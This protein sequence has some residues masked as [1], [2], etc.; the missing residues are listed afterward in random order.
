MFSVISKSAI[1]PSRSGRIAVIEPG[2]RPTIRLASA[3]IARMRREPRVSRWTATTE[4]S[5]QMIPSPFT[6]TSVLAV[7][8]S[9]ARSLENQPKTELRTTGYCPLPTRSGAAFFAAE[10]PRISP[11]SG[12][13]SPHK[14]GKIGVPGPLPPAE[15]G[16]RWIAG[17][18]SKPRNLR[19]EKP[20]G[21][22]C[23]TMLD[24]M[25]RHAYSWTTRI[26]LGLITVVFIFWGL[27]S[28]LFRQVHPV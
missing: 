4:G 11:G 3:P 13:P 9:I 26:L 7:P 25:R 12:L 6:Y 16:N 23:G 27:G 8:R 5:L 20:R 10:P 15:Q 24:L 14:G 22:D 1:T 17:Q 19:G 28:G 2:V 18:A 21:Y